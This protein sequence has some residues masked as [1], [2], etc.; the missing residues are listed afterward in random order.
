[1][2]NGQHLGHYPPPRQSTT[3]T[4]GTG[5]D[6]N[7]EW[8]VLGAKGEEICHKGNIGGRALAMMDAI[9]TKGWELPYQFR[10]FA[11]I[12]EV[13]YIQLPNAQTGLTQNYDPKWHE[14]KRNNS[15]K[16]VWPTL[17]D[18]YNA[19]NPSGGPWPP[20]WPPSTPPPPQP[21]PTIRPGAP[22]RRKL[23]KRPAREERT[24]HDDYPDLY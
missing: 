19:A 18:I 16:I 14:L 9:A 22:E 11:D 20:P 4:L 13:E 17:L 1:M 3:S 10:V 6:E 5:C 7:T 2:P 21:P 24:W 15:G 8:I 23:K 12:G